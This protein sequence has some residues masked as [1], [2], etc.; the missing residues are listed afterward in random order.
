MEI[1]IIFIYAVIT[2]LS[3]T[4]LVVTLLSY[5]K[6]K[7]NKLLFISLVFLFLFIRGILLS[8]NLVNDQI[9]DFVSSGYI[10]IFDVVVLVLLYV[11]YSLKR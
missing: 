3:L 10:W 4:L 5:I 6:Y 8:L 2:I 11:A 1:D 9:A 7:N